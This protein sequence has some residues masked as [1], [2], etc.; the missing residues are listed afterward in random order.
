MLTQQT[1]TFRVGDLDIDFGAYR[2]YRNHELVRLTRTEW[3]LLR[4]LVNHKN[5]VLSHNQLLHRVWGQ[6]YNDESDYV[7][8]YVSRLR[9]KLE[10]DTTNPQYIITEPGIGY[11]FQADDSRTIIMPL[12]ESSDGVRVINPL[13]QRVD[14]RF[15]GRE[16]EQQLLLDL[17]ENRTRLI[18]IYGRA[19]IGKTALVCKVLADLQTPNAKIPTDG[20]V[21]LSAAS[22]GI[23]MARIFADFGRLLGDDKNELDSGELAQRITAL[24]ERLS[25]GDYILL[26]DNLESVQNSATGELL[27]ADLQLFFKMAVEQSGALRII[28][29][30]REPLFIPASTRTYE[31]RLELNEGL[32]LE[33]S[34]ALLRRCDVDG[35]AGLRDASAE[36]LGEIAA[37]TRGYPRALEAVVSLLV[38]DPFLTPENL[39]E[40]TFPASDEISEVL[41]AQALERLDDVSQR[42]MQITAAFRGDVALD[43]LERIATPYLPQ[44]SKLRNILQRLIQ[45]YFLSYDSANK[46]ITM[47]PLDRDYCY[48]RIPASD[49]DFNL[50]ALHQDIAALYKA[51]QKQVNED[52]EPYLNEFNHLVRAESYS[53]AAELL[54]WLDTTHLSQENFHADAA[55]MYS[56]VVPHLPQSALLRTCLLRH[57]EAYRRIAR[58]GDAMHAFEAAYQQA[59]AAKHAADI[60]LALNS[61]GWAQYDL[62]HFE[63]ALEFWER[64]LSAFRELDNTDGMTDALGGIGWV[65]YLMGEYDAAISS[66]DRA[67]NLSAQDGDEQ[68][69]A[70]NLGDKGVVYIAQE[71]FAEAIATLDEALRISDVVGAGREGSYKGGYLATAYLLNNQLADAD[72]IARL[73]L[74]SGGALVNEPVLQTLH[75]VILARMG[76]KEAAVTA[77]ERA[78]ALADK[79]LGVTLGLYRV[80]YARGLA[81]AGLALLQDVSALSNA[82]LDYGIAA[83]I[84]REAGVRHAQVQLLDALAAIDGEQLS[85]IREMLRR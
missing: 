60:A 2:L 1:T 43:D 35:T 14:D 10:Y 79:I 25:R 13:P 78:I 8:T 73:T 48:N 31:R 37:G 50:I 59:Q 12:A 58:L 38:G 54:L 55:D 62:G 82:L 36:L 3:S 40:A 5:Q 57:G 33:D 53:E 11:R 30:S 66:F 63:L 68:A 28:I 9:R 81:N 85:P 83:A 74:A 26:L 71:R 75:G 70:L 80:R 18:S 46:H 15:I 69:R 41:V 72:D 23:G 20:M 34:I 44:E 21:F 76:Q 84:C 49:G 4:E 24:L 16:R 29:T 39:V 42:V 27:D 56:R 47:H 67:E 19:G 77:F 22:T 17:L 32:S 65:R 61:M 6:E 52:I 45:T 51:E 64:A 7:H